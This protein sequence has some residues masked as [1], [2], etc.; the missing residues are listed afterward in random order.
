MTEKQMEQA[1]KKWL[2][3]KKYLVGSQ[4][5]LIGK[6]RLDLVAYDKGN[7]VFRV[8]ECKS[9]SD[10]RTPEK[11]FGHVTTYIDAISR[12]VDEFVDSAS[13]TM[14]MRFGRW[15]EATD[16]GRRIQV[17][18]FVALRDGACSRMQCIRD[19]KTRHSDVG[20][21]RCKENSQ[22]KT[23]MKNE[24]G[25]HNLDLSKAQ[26]KTFSLRDHWRLPTGAT[27]WN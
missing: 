8:V 25:T 18:F 6:F 7:G 19:Q 4:I 26:I 5:P 16:C 22:C 9:T 3:K 24:D 15:M 13:R 14:K 11:A 12:H 17:E 27:N 10:E 21:I 20:I 1:V 23:Y 2:E